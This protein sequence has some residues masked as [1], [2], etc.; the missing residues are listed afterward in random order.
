MIPPESV[1][2]A[3]NGNLMSGLAMD[4]IMLDAGAIL[5]KE[6]VTMPTYRMFSIDERHP[7]MQR[8]SRGG[9]NIAVEVW[10]VPLAGLASILLQEPPGLCVGKVMLSEGEEVLGVLGEAILCENRTEITRFG[11][12]KAYLEQK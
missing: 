8:V 3:V 7:A 10:L 9:A 6:A 1:L 2:L 12:W 11:G 4:Y 5:V